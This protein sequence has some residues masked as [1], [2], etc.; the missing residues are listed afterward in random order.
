MQPDTNEA[1]YS[2][3]LNDLK[4]SLKVGDGE[5]EILTENRNQIRRRNA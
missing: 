4:P 3:Q 1:K 2:L 5:Q